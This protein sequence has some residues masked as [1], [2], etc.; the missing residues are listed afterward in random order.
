MPERDEGDGAALVR[1][2]GQVPSA[3]AT[4]STAGSSTRPGATGASMSPAW[5]SS[6]GPR[7]ICGSP[8]PGVAVRGQASCP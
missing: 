6:A 4:N 1:P 5:A 2:G 8:S 7:S 3:E